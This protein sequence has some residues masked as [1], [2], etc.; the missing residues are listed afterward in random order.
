MAQWLWR[1][2]IESLTAGKPAEAACY[3]RRSLLYQPTK[4][5]ALRG[6]L[7]CQLKPPA[8]SG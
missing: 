2:G 4:L 1:F 7:R 6:W 3:F 5:G 8:A